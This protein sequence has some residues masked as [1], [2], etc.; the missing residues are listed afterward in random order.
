M[1]KFYTSATFF[2][3]GFQKQN[4]FCRSL[5]LIMQMFLIEF[6]FTML[7]LSKRYFNRTFDEHSI[8]CKF[9]AGKKSMITIDNLQNCQKIYVNNDN[10][11]KNDFA[12][13]FK[14]CF[15]G[16]ISIS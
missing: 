7:K 14:K 15:N 2:K 10:I 16:S 8:K 12:T 1:L 5:Q 11:F 9:L 13:D 3:I 4:D 6:S